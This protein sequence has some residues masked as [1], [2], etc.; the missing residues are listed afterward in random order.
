MSEVLNDRYEESR[1]VSLLACDQ[2]E[3]EVAWFEAEPLSGEDER[4][5]WD[6]IFRAR[7]APLNG[8]FVDLAKDARER[9]A[10]HYQ[11]LVCN[12]MRGFARSFPP[13]DWK[14]N[15]STTSFRDMEFL[16]LVQEANIAL[17][18]AFDTCPSDLSG[19]FK[20]WVIGCVRRTLR[21]LSYKTGFGHLENGRVRK[22]IADIVAVSQRYW[23]DYGRFPSPSELSSLLGLSLSRV[24]ELLYYRRLGGVESIEAICERY[25]EP[26]DYHDFASLYDQWTED[27]VA[28]SEVQARCIEQA[29]VQLSPLRRKVMCLRYGLCGEDPHMGREVCGLLGIKK[30][31]EQDAVNHA[32]KQL[33]VLLAPLY[34]EEQVVV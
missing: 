20:A 2:Y 16:D 27:E 6:R 30:S 21:D 28:C 10:E 25:E 13:A 1:D 4:K 8:W 17:I 22:G 29:V 15:L 3:R 7:N 32:R 9:L 12:L 14:A 33:R 31:N 19:P 11:P 34:E 26:S 23:S 18:R 24:Y 5:Y